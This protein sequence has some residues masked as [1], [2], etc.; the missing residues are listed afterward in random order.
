MDIL[1]RLCVYVCVLLYVVAYKRVPCGNGKC[2]CYKDS[3]QQRMDCANKKILSVREILKDIPMNTTIL[4]LGGNNISLLEN[5]TFENCENL[6]NLEVL[7]FT[8]N[9]IKAIQT[10]AF[11]GLGLLK[12]L[13]S[14]SNYLTTI[15]A[16]IPANVQ[17]L[18]LS[19]NFIRKLYNYTFSGI[20]NAE[21]KLK[22]LHLQNNTI[23]EIEQYAFEGLHSLEYLD[24]SNNFIPFMTRGLVPAIFKPM[25]NLLELDLQNNTMT[26]LQDLRYPDDILSDAKSLQTLKIDGIANATFGPGFDDFLKNL[27]TL[28]LSGLTGFCKIGTLKNDTFH[29]LNSVKHLDISYCD[30]TFVQAEAL[31]P[32]H[33]FDF[34]DMTENK[35]LGF[36][37]LPNVFFGLRNTTA[38]TLKYSSMFRS[39]MGTELKVK[40]LQHFNETKLKNLYFDNNAL[41]VCEDDV[42]SYFPNTIKYI[43][44]QSNRL[45]IGYWILLLGTLTNL[46]VVDNS[47]QYRSRIPDVPWSQELYF[48][49]KRQNRPLSGGCTDIS[50]IYPD[51]LKK[52]FFIDSKLCLFVCL[53]VFNDAPTLM[54]H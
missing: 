33:Q 9:N 46:E 44:I 22:K 19:H 11:K 16:L 28:N 34:I 6:T 4:D 24:L 31:S 21:H 40:H 15:S 38:E 1:L 51:K 41:E 12:E 23:K 10:L 27:T 48:D 18:N 42:L 14:S 52:F 50:F 5:K 43:S 17:E 35:D 53:F 39:R 8:N 26:E 49:K 20:N 45:M 30:L 7:N 32:L 13:D 25:R 2:M 29:Y 36:L 54:G 3:N 37:A 47:Y